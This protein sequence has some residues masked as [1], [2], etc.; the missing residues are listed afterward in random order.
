MTQQINPD[1]I[2]I[3]TKTFTNWFNDRLRGNLRLDATTTGKITDLSTDLQDG[4]LLIQL[5]NV[6]ARPKKI[7][8]YNKRPI[9][10]PQKMENITTALKFLVDD[11]TKFVNIGAFRIEPRLLA[12]FARSAWFYSMHVF[13]QARKTSSTAI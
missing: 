12:R 6:L 2:H 1:W 10:K 5:C 8:R 7:T 9:L 3:Q 11:G 4:L 13:L